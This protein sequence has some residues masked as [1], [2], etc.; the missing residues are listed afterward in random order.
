MKKEVSHP[1]ND[2]QYIKQVSNNT[3]KKE[4]MYNELILCGCDVTIQMKALWHCSYMAI[5]IYFL[6]GTLR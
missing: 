6:H 1:H 4:K 3:F 2:A 5:Y